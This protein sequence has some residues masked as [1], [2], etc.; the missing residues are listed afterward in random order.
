ME[1]A[2]F[3]LFDEITSDSVHPV[4]RNVCECYYAPRKYETTIRVIIPAGLVADI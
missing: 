1:T 3:P 4:E 2:T